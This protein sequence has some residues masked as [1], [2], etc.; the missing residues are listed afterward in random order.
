MHIIC[1]N[2]SEN[3]FYDKKQN[4]LCADA[5]TFFNFN[6]LHNEKNFFPLEININYYPICL[7]Q[8]KFNSIFERYIIRIGYLK[9][10][11][12]VI[13]GREILS[14]LHFKNFIKY[15]FIKLYLFGCNNKKSFLPSYIKSTDICDNSKKKINMTKAVKF[16]EINKIEIILNN[17]YEVQ[18]CSFAKKKLNIKTIV[19]YHSNFFYFN[20][21]K[22]KYNSGNFHKKF[23]YSSLLVTLIANNRIL[24]KKSGIKYC[25]YLPNPT[26]F[27]SDKIKISNLKYKNI[28]MLGRSDKIKRYEIGIKAMKYVIEKEPNAKLYII[29]I[30]NNRYDKFLKNYSAQLGL[31]KNIIFKKLT[32]NIT[33]YYKNSS[34]F[35]LT[36]I[37]EGCPMSLSE[38]KLYG[39]PSIVVGM[40]Y[41]SSS[42]N[43]VININEDNPELIANEILKLLKDKKYRELEGKKA[44]LSVNDFQ[45]EEIYKRWIEIFI[46]VKQGDKLIEKYIKKYD[47]YNDEEDFKENQILYKKIF[48]KNLIEFKEFY[49]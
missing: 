12:S 42:K 41:L 38:S 39:L 19:L 31:K 7:N 48:H 45:N 44:R 25:T 40:N 24:W 36:S 43:G 21:R 5:L 27:E 4:K 17:E 13:G 8:P 49:F 3:Y 30:G 37:F 18:L 14:F 11:I 46:S 26:T 10:D 15:P 20:Y 34:I 33:Q 32:K 1:L 23:I 9:H 6:R 22:K 29:G 47:K 16:L 35:L 2:K 28:L